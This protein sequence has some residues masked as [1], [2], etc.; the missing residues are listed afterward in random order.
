MLGIALS[1]VNEV[2]DFDRIGGH[3]IDQDVVGVHN[4]LSCSWHSTRPEHEG[5]FGQ[6]LGTS[7]YRGVKA[8]RCAYVPLGNVSED[9]IEVVQCACAPDE[10]QHASLRRDFL[11]IS[12]APPIASS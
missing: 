2:H 4:R 10:P 3:A 7:F 1:G 6:S 9:I 5:L 11:M 12:R 8:L